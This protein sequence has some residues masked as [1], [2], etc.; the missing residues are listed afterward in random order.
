MFRN[1]CCRCRWRKRGLAATPT[2]FGISFTTKFL[3][4]AGAL[5]HV[6]LDGT[7]LVTH[8]GVEMGQGLHTKVAQVGTW[9][10]AQPRAVGPAWW[11]LWRQGLLVLVVGWERRRA[12]SVGRGPARCPLV[13]LGHH[14]SPS[15]CRFTRLP[16]QVAAQALNV[17]LSKVFI[18]E[19]STDKVPNASPTAASASSDM[20][21]AATLDACKQIAD[22][23]AP[24]RCVRGVGGT[25]TEA[26][27]RARALSAARI[28]ANL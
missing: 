11:L 18:S 4:Q 28:R 22:R 7:V 25:R 26:W 20:Y 14:A 3:N 9:A 6:Y 23:L 19:T 12:L 8:G 27:L 10:H 21:G 16:P 24:Y 1:P 5:V 2:K 13:T 17:P 15:H